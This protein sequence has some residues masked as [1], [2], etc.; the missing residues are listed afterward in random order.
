MSMEPLPA[1]NLTFEVAGRRVRVLDK[2]QVEACGMDKDHDGNLSPQE[3]RDGLGLTSVEPGVLVDME[4]CLDEFAAHLEGRIPEQ[5]RHYR[6][7]VDFH[8]ALENLE[9]QYPDRAKVVRLGKTRSGRSVEALLVSEAPSIEKPKDKAVVVTGLTH[10]REWITGEATIQMAEKFLARQSQESMSQAEVWFVPVVNPDGYAY[11][12]EDDNYWRKNLA[13]AEGSAVPASDP[14][15]P[16]GVDLNRNC[17]DPNSPQSGVFRLEAD[18]PGSTAD[19]VGGSDDP[20]GEC[21]RGERGASEPEVQALLDLELHRGNVK[22]QL[23]LHSYGG[24]IAFPYGFTAEKP[25]Q[26]D[27]YREVAAKMNH[28]IAGQCG[29]P[30]KVVEGMGPGLYPTTGAF[31]DVQD[32][33]GILS[34]TLEVGGSFQPKGEQIKPLC[35]QAVAAGLV[36]IDEVLGRA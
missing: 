33:N 22:G 30:Y 3:L 18:K 2:H 8:R 10:A 9:R 24:M 26:I 20:S 7:N 29:Y 34:V 13:P 15:N 25:K 11:S 5:V 12:R 28:A 17:V 21:Y 23:D 35:D 1:R 19:D 6:S 16:T 27:I 32:L 14:N 36:F 4:G 31:G